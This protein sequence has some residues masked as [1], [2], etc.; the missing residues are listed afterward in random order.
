VRGV[1]LEAET[2]G[3]ESGTGKLA[4]ADLGRYESEGRRVG[5]ELGGAAARVLQKLLNVYAIAAGGACGT[6]C[7]KQSWCFGGL[8]ETVV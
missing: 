2:D 7:F 4:A 1:R 6:W 5:L 8:P 3:T